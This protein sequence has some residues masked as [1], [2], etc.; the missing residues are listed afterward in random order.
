M[1][2]EEDNELEMINTTTGESLNYLGNIAYYRNDMKIG[3]VLE[4]DSLGLDLKL[5]IEISGF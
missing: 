2:T 5:R 4:L 3:N 1:Y